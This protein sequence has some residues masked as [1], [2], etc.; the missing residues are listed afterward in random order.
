MTVNIELKTGVNFYPGIEKQVVELVHGMGWQ[1]RILYSSFNHCSV[2]KVREYDP[3]ARIAFLYMEQLSHVADYALMNNVYAV[4]PSVL[5]TT[6]ED[7]MRMCREKN[8]KVNVWT[9]NTEEDMRRLK[10]AAVNS[11]ITNYPDIAKR[12]ME[13]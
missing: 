4:N 12:I 13:E 6:L 9:V 7:E 5:C 2:L 8:V 1:N 3:D 11:V 10:R